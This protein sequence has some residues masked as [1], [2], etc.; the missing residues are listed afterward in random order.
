M[1]DAA[2]LMREVAAWQERR[3]A[4]TCTV[5]W[6]FT[7]ADARIKLTRLYR[8]P[9]PTVLFHKGSKRVWFLLPWER[10]SGL[11]GQ[12]HQRFTTAVSALPSTGVLPLRGTP[13]E[14]S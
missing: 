10:C 12:C 6:R 3:N 13:G 9:K 1:P 2:T 5:D 4:A 11:R 8:S 7:T 14:L